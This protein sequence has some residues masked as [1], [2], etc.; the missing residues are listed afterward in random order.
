M[1]Q[2]PALRGVL[3]STDDLD[4]A[5]SFYT[6]TLGFSLSFRDGDRYAS[7]D[8]GGTNVALAATHDHPSPG[9]TV[10][11]LKVA[12]V[13]PAVDELAAGGAEVLVAP[14]DGAHE[15][16]ALIRAPGGAGLISV[17]GPEH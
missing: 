17:Y 7:L 12:R 13:Q 10:L 14:T 5:L 15:V 4:T 8:A 6:D 9:D 1:E 2:S 3:L 16:R 11:T